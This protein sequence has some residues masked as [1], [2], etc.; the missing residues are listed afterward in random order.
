MQNLKG[1]DNGIIICN[2]IDNDSI[3]P[4]CSGLINRYLCERKGVKNAMEDK[5]FD[6]RIFESES[7]SRL[8][9]LQ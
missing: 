1:N 6:G 3:T 2:K 7:K 9:S 5:Y 4:F 8:K